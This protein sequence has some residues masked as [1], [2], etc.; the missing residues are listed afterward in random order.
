MDSYH[1]YKSRPGVGDLYL[2]AKNGVVG[3]NR[4]RGEF[5]TES[6]ATFVLVQTKK[7]NLKEM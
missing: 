2:P 1:N 4:T 6:V 7:V 5:I 3:N